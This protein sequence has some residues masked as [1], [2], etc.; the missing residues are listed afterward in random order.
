MNSDWKIYTIDEL[1]A[2]MKSAISMGPFGSRIKTENFVSDG[3]PIIRGNNLNANY[4]HDDD[5]AFLTQEKADEFKSSTV[6]PEDIIFTHRGTIGQ[7]GIIPES[8]KYPKYIVSQSQ[9]KLSVNKNLV[10]PFYLF[11]FFKTKLGQ[12]ELLKNASQVGVPSIARPTSALKQIKIKLPNLE[13]QNSIVKILKTLDE[14]IELNRQMCKT[15]EDI[16]STLF[17]SW[18]I[19]FDPV[20]AKAEDREPEG[21][22]P[23]IAELFPDSFVES[24]LGFIPYEW[25]FEEI[26]NMGNIICGKTPPTNE[27]DNYGND[28]PF[29][30]IPDMHDRIWVLTTSKSISKRGENLQKNKTLPPQTICVSCIATPG[31][32]TLT[33]RSAQTNQQINA[34]IPKDKKLTYYYFFLIKNNVNKI[35]S[36]GAGGS[37]FHNLNKSQ[38][39]SIR[40]ML[41]PASLGHQFSEIITPLM[42]NI[43]EKEEE[44]I[45]LAA[46]RNSLLPKLMDGKINVKETEKNVSA[47]T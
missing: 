23:E 6:F 12:F 35:R 16:A 10:N 13:I 46:I 43:K 30:T 31:L 7:V 19:N 20:K 37:V 1:K 24:P 2:D 21:L 5:F 14:K 27:S 42:E 15:L 38:F 39:S 40:V 11:Y 41:A 47:L 8:S 28:C 18:F 36:H 33:S 17:K 25:K 34:L 44:N 4:L 9:M 3:V 26:Q 22:C 32:V 29:I 45:L